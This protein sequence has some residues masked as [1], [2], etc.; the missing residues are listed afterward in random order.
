MKNIKH[1]AFNKIIQKDYGDCFVEIVRNRNFADFLKTINKISDF[2]SDY[3]YKD[4][5][6]EDEVKSGKNKFI[7]DLFEI[8]AESF[9]IQFS[10]D[11]RIG[12][13]DY[14]PVPSEDDNG[15]DGY[16]KN[17]SGE[18][19][20]I[21][22]KYRGNPTYVLKERDIKQFGYQSIVNYD[23]D[24]KKSDNMI[25]FTSCEGVHWYTDSKVFAGKLRVINGETI[26]SLIDNNEGFWQTFKNL[27]FNSVHE[28]GVERLTQI[29]K[30]KI[31]Y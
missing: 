25:I 15:V 7:G 27:I 14:Q 23:I 1:H 16:G 28:I 24:W 17:I 20:T 5:E 6:L 12:V 31:N 8:F 26:S 19:C 13:F 2:A 21:Q 30:E 11:N 9:F 3:G 18:S 22:V 10:S 4:K 29:F